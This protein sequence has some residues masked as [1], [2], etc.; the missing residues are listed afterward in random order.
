MIDEGAAV[1]AALLAAERQARKLLRQSKALLVA[2]ENERRWH[3]GPRMITVQPRRAK[4]AHS[5]APQG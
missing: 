3:Q 1:A 5:A 2:V 4:H